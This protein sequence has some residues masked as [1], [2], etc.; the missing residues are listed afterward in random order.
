MCILQLVFH[1]QLALELF[2]LLQQEKLAEV[3]DSRIL[4]LG[5]VLLVCMLVLL[6]VAQ[7]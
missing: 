1:K 6:V 7:V 5:F 3:M 4:S 2:V